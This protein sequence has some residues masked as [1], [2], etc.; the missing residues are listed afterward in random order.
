MWPLLAQEVTVRGGFFLDSLKIG[1]QTGFYLTAKYPSKLN[2]IFPDS[3]Y[4]FSP[5]EY[6]RKRYFPTQTI[7]GESYDSVV[8]YLSTFEVDRVQTLSLPVFQLNPQDCTKFTSPQDTILLME[9]VK[10]L[11]D[12]LTAENLPLRVNTIYE[13]V[14]YLFNYPILI[15][16]IAVLLVGSIIVWF[17][18]GKKIIQHFRLKKMLK[19]H[20]KFLDTYSA[21]VDAIKT[22]FSAVTTES[23]LSLW[24]KYMENLEARPYTKLT[25]RETMQLENNDVLGRNLH[26]ID[27]AIYGHSTAVIESLENLK[28]FADQRFSKK[29]EE[30]KHG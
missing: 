17:V 12:T 22:A 20:Q 25:T 18:F 1:D 4:N 3:T 7:Q 24:K 30:V 6:E 10:N 9:L 15:I 29:L 26:A 21:E 23:A 19:A 2:I 8:Y 13:N 27:G 5:F 16:S 28:Q 14:S 11:P